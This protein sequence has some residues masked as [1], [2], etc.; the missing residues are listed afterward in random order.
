[1]DMAFAKDQDKAVSLV[2]KRYERFGQRSLIKISYI[3]HLKSFIANTAC[4]EAV[5]ST[6]QMG[7][8]KLNP[9]ISILTIFCPLLVLTPAFQF[10]PLGDDGGN[11]NQWQ[12]VY[13]FYKTPMV[14]YISTFISYAFFL[15]LYTSV[16]LL[17]Y[18]TSEILVYVWLSIMIVESCHSVQH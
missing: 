8:I 7:F 3:G 2:D 11:L 12:K 1:M 13:V 18:R 17:E 10:L 16:A 4:Q 9:W 5:R 15:M 6:W 14:K